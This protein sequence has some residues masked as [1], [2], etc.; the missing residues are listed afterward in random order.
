MQRD[1]TIENITKA[2]KRLVLLV[3][4][5]KNNGPGANEAMARLNEVRAL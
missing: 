5:D 1:E 4:P 2:R 3:H